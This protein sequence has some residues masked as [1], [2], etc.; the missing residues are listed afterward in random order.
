MAT[1]GGQNSHGSNPRNL[2]LTSLFLLLHSDGHCRLLF[3]SVCVCVE[4]KRHWVNDST[5]V[6]C[7]LFTSDGIRL[8]LNDG[9]IASLCL[10]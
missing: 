2:F 9:K 7:W 6:D 5:P 3:E 1:L 10:L 8:N 4:M